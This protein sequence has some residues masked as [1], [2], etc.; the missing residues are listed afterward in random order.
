M[1][2]VIYLFEVKEGQEQLFEKAWRDLTLF[3]YEYE[4][5]LGSRLHKQ[6]A[7][8]YIGYAQWPDEYT[9]ENSGSNLPEESNTIRE[10]MKSSCKEI[11]TLYKLDVTDDLLK[12]VVNE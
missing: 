5:S 11:K 1:F 9:W 6:N 3:I 7:S 2:T 10:I 8:T 4:G 12:D